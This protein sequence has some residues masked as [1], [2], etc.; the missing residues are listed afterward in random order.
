M[1]F[2]THRLVSS[3]STR[4]AGSQSQPLA[5]SIRASVGHCGC[6]C[7]RVQSVMCIFSEVA[8]GLRASAEGSTQRTV[9]VR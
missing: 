8:D 2:F 1:F 5:G 3:F 7:W 9:V 4:L 6:A